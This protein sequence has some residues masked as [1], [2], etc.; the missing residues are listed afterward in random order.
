MK[1][2]EQYFIVYKNPCPTEQGF[3]LVFQRIIVDDNALI[4]QLL[5][6]FDLGAVNIHLNQNG[7]VRENINGFN[8]FVVIH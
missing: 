4:G 1:A 7:T 3:L 5:N 6:I 8:V 2:W